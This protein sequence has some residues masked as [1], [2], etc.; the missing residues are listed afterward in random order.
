MNLETLIK[1]IDALKKQ[2]SDLQNNSTP[3]ICDS[4]HDEDPADIDNSDPIGTQSTS[5]E[6]TMFVASN[7]SEEN[8]QRED[9]TDVVRKEVQKIINQF[10]TQSNND[11]SVSTFFDKMEGK[12]V[13]NEDVLLLEDQ[14]K[15]TTTHIIK[16]ASQY[17]ITQSAYNPHSSPDK[18]A[19]EKSKIESEDE[20]D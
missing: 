20:L 2:V 14:R 10:Q 12:N 18:L 16:R 9:I 17:W 3:N 4:A 8:K 5:Q 19:E 11:S 1:Q 13:T 7:L 6:L 15:T